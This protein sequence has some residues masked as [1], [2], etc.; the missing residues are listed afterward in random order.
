MNLN[1][2]DI[3]SIV[4][5]VLVVTAS[6]VLFFFPNVV[7]YEKSYVAIEEKKDT[8]EVNNQNIKQNEAQIASLDSS[9]AALKEQAQMVKINADREQAALS[10]VPTTLDIPSF[11]ISMEKEA[12]AK[13]ITLKV[14]YANIQ[15]NSI[16]TAPAQQSESNNTQPEGANPQSQPN[17]SQPVPNAVQPVPN[18]SQPAVEPVPNAS[19]PAP[20]SQSGGPITQPA[21]PNTQPGS[22]TAQPSVPTA[23]PGAPIDSAKNAEESPANERPAKNAID[24]FNR[25]NAVQAASA[26][27]QTAVVPIEVSGGYKNIREYISYLDGLGLVRPYSV[28]MVSEGKVV[29]ANISL[30]IMYGEVKR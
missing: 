22:P 28:N 13:N 5:A 4:I 21:V 6:I 12:Q 8:I 25:N 18:A 16:G 7:G 27:L 26:G 30:N 15:K 19:Q 23:Q 3:I 9:V 2:K 14:D 17:A 11:L 20:N 29:T 24:N 1:K 10:E